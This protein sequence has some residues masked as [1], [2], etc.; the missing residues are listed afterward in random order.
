LVAHPEPRLLARPYDDHWNLANL[1]KLPGLSRWLN[2]FRKTLGS[3]KDFDGG[4]YDDAGRPWY[5]YHQI[6]RDKA[7][8]AAVIAFPD[9]ATHAHFHVFTDRRS[10]DNY[11]P[12]VLV[13]GPIQPKAVVAALLNSS[14]ALFWLKQTCFNKGA[15]EDEELDRFEY[16]GGKVEQLPVPEALAGVLRDNRST[17]ADKLVEPS[18]ACC[19]R[20]QQ[21]PGLA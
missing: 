11:S 4:T 14:A 20:G 5:E 16:A 15:G 12:V 17:L 13:E 18:Q 9:L 2:L 21:M 7:K 3:R 10:F 1:Q 8:A 6:D 19:G